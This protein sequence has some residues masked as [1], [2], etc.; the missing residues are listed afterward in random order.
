MT[1]YMFLDHRERLT[2]S[3]IEPRGGVTETGF[4]PV[5]AGFI[6]L[7]RRSTRLLATERTSPGRYGPECER[8]QLD[9]IIRRR[10]GLTGG[11]PRHAVNAC[12]FGDLA[13][14]EEAANAR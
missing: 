4:R 12:S 3:N 5:S 11:R 2:R 7:L 8:T 1:I 13:R 10:E 9:A 14:E 6:G